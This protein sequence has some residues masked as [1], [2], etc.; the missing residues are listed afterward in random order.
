MHWFR[1]FSCFTIANQLTHSHTSRERRRWV[2]HKHGSTS[3]FLLF[4]T[5]VQCLPFYTSVSRTGQWLA[6]YTQHLTFVRFEYSASVCMH[7][8]QGIRLAVINIEYY[9]IRLLK[10]KP[11]VISLSLR[12][13]RL[14]VKSVLF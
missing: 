2:K 4:K 5:K 9:I 3:L 10:F 12:I 11:R 13:L 1:L 6:I 14:N 8:F 7:F